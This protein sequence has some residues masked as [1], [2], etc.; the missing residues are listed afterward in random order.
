MRG[1]SVAGGIAG[2]SGGRT[3]LRGDSAM[4][5]ESEGGG[6]GSEP[7]PGSVMQAHGPCPAGG[8]SPALPVL[9]TPP[10]AAAAHTLHDRVGW[11][12]G[13][14]GGSG[15]PGPWTRLWF[16]PPS[17]RPSQPGAISRAVGREGP[18][19][20]GA[21]TACSGGARQVGGQHHLLRG[22]ASGLASLASWLNVS[23]PRKGASRIAARPSA[24]SDVVRSGAP[25][26]LSLR[27][28]TCVARGERPAF[29][30]ST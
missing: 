29:R 11:G 25:Q 20:S 28:D 15:R 9:P 8:R 6:P 14:P 5:P 7:P 27:R 10:A 23:D 19:R 12:P 24:A 13:P 26:S 1:E 30:V 3:A 21:S 18:H 16:A 22:C 2:G 4:G 17:C